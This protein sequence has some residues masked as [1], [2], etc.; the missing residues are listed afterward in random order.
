[1]RHF[2]LDKPPVKKA[3]NT[4]FLSDREAAQVQSIMLAFGIERFDA[5]V[6][7]WGRGK[8]IEVSGSLDKLQ[9]SCLL[10]IARYLDGYASTIEPESP[11]RPTLTSS[12]QSEAGL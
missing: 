5:S 2:C 1:M 7:L 12:V 6:R 10:A 8:T 4:R 3:L 9:L 11:L